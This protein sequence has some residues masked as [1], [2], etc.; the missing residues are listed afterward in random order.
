MLAGINTAAYWSTIE[1]LMGCQLRLKKFNLLC[2][3]SVGGSTS[4]LDVAS[5]SD[6][7]C[8]LLYLI[9]EMEAWCTFYFRWYCPTSLLVSHSQWLSHTNMCFNWPQQWCYAGEYPCH[10]NVW[11]LFSHSF[12]EDPW[13]DEG[14]SC[15]NTVNEGSTITVQTLVTLKV[16]PH[17]LGVN[18]R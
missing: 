5:N 11:L 9:R 2:S 1:Q 16:G 8:S 17:V 14:T 13:N 6:L 3:S 10:C 18:K 7:L 12:G 15:S 4:W